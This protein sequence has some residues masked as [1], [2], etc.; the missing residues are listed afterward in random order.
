MESSGFPYKFPKN[1]WETGAVPPRNQWS[2]FTLFI[3]LFFVVAHFVD[4]WDTPQI[5]GEAVEGLKTDLASP[6]VVSWPEN[7]SNLHHPEVE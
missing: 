5:L 3:K 2:Y 6:L 1:K 7:P 4:S